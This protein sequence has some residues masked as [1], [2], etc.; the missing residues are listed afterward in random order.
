M[1][2]LRDLVAR[3]E[4]IDGLSMV[5]ASWARMWEDGSVVVANDP[6]WKTLAEMACAARR[7]LLNGLEALAI[8]DDPTK[9][10]SCAHRL[11]MLC[12]SECA[13]STESYVAESSG[14]GEVLTHPARAVGR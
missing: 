10:V 8:H 11:K 1:S 9:S 6:S 2:I 13:Q 4:D 14:V 3:D 5:K 12:L 7:A